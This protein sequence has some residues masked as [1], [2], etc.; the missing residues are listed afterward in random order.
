MAGSL[1]PLRSEIFNLRD[2]WV[3]IWTET[4]AG[5]KD[6]QLTE[7][8]LYVNSAV[9]SDKASVKRSFQCGAMGRR[10]TTFGHDYTLNMSRFQ[11]KYSDD[12]GIVSVNPDDTYQI[13]FVMTNEDNMNY[14][15]TH[16]LKHCQLESRSM[17]M[18]LLANTVPTQ[19]AVGEYSPPS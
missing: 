19:W 11:A 8:W 2:L 14:T 17:R 15:E 12:F 6:S 7:Y 1:D 10:L 5:V 9:L 16:T 18:D 3:E 4:I 13:L